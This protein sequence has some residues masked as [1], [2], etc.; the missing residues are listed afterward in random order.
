MKAPKQMGG[1][2][3]CQRKKNGKRKKRKK[4]GKRKSGKKLSVPQ[5][6]FDFSIA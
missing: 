2:K 6:F 5:A 3:R 1:E 4:N